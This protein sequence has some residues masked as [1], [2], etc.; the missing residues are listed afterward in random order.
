MIEIAQGLVTK[1]FSIGI[2][3]HEMLA[4]MVETTTQFCYVKDRKS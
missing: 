1:I 2:I 3:R 4:R